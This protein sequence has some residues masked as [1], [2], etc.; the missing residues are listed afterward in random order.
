MESYDNRE[1]P[2]FEQG[3]HQRKFVETEIHYSAK[4]LRGIVGDYKIAKH[5][6]RETYITER[7]FEYASTVVVPKAPEIRKAVKAAIASAGCYE[8]R[9]LGGGEYVYRCKIRESEFEVM[10]DY[11]GWHQL[12]YNIFIPWLSVPSSYRT[13]SV[14]KLFGLSFR[15]WDNIVVPSLEGSIEALIDE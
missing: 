7:L 15:G 11:G 3:E 6:N 14:E 10:I 12:R 1:A 5:Q 4:D 9:S 13:F 8:I 2:S